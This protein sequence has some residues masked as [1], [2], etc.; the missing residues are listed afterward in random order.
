MSVCLNILKIWRTRDIFCLHKTQKQAFLFQHANSASPE[1]TDCGGIGGGGDVKVEKRKATLSG[2]QC[3]F[4]AL[5]TELN[6]QVHAD[7]LE[8]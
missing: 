2:K 7:P 5:K 3:S 8:V 4:W 6:R 1:V